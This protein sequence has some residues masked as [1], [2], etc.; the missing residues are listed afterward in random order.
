MPIVKLPAAGKWENYHKTGTSALLARY[1]VRSSDA[2]CGREDL[3]QVSA[4]LRDWLQSAKAAG[5]SVRPVGGAWSPSNIQLVQQGW[6]LNTRRFNRLFRIA[7]SDLADPT[8]VGAQSL[9]LVEAGTQIDEINDKLEADPPGGMARSMHSTGASNGQTIAGA[10]ATGTHGSVLEAGGI[11]DHVRAIQLVTPS[12]V[13]WIEPSTPL[14]NDDFITAT[15][16]TAIRD[17]TVFA[18]AQ[19]AVGSLGIVTALV[20]ETVPR[21]LTQPF[22]KVVA[23]EEAHLDLLARGDYRGFSAAYGFDCEP[24]FIMVITNPYRPFKSKA[25]VRMF[26]KKPYQSDYPRADHAQIGAGYDAF[27]LLGSIFRAFPWAPRHIIPFIM[28]QAVGKGAEPNKPPVFASWGETTETHKP[29]ANLFTGAIFCDRNDIVRAFT[30]LCQAYTS[31]GGATVVTMRFMKGGHGLLTPARWEN[32]AGLDCDGPGSARTIKAFG[33]V[34]AALDAQNIAFTRH[35][36]KHNELDAARVA[37]DYGAD[38]VR[39]KAARDR[40][41][42]NPADRKLFSSRELDALGLTV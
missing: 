3:N 5:V 36:G 15:G 31:A 28:R 32:T 11:Q 21:Y 20:L 7:A 42:P 17:D 30:T 13:H 18:A 1:A 12:A 8:S 2:G 6:M 26:Y 25:V 10:C 24:Y 37:Q 33:R 9:V 22:F 39:W 14:M 34:I 29:L 23:F 4:E 40:L 27:S 19:V 38:L 35:W 16:S 41:I